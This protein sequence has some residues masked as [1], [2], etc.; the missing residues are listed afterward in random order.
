MSLYDQV[1]EIRLYLNEYETVPPPLQRLDAGKLI[2]YRSQD[3]LGDLSDS[4]K[5]FEPPERG[6]HAVCDDDIIY[7]ADYIDHMRFCADELGAI[8]GC[9]GV[10]LADR[11]V[12]S[13]YRCRSVFHKFRSV[14]GDRR[15]HILATSSLFYDTALFNSRCKF[16]TPVIDQ[17]PLPNMADI[18]FGKLAAEAGIPM[19]CIDHDGDWLRQNPKTDHSNTIYTRCRNDDAPMTETVNGVEWPDLEKEVA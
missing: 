11:P 1:D 18:W 9:H 13:Y 2:I 6:Y 14:R 3:H 12:E 16:P 10:I 19:V 15:V 8:V 5:F 4:G 17:F 7:P